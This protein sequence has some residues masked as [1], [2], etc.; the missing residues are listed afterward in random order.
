M[1]VISIPHPLLRTKAEPVSPTDITLP[2]MQEFVHE[3]IITM[4]DNRGIGIAA[5]QV[6]K[7]LRLIIVDTADG[8]Q[9]FFNPRVIWQ[10]IT[11]KVD[12]EGCLSVPN[13]YGLV[14]RPRSIIINFHDI[15]GVRQRLK[16]CGLFARVLCHETDHLN[17]VLFTDRMTKEIY[18]AL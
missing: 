8:P 3:L 18:H 13:T 12:E 11:T 4:K 7:S 10:S 14:K 15:K 1:K 17:G 9:A 5:P 16:A 2:A 6:G